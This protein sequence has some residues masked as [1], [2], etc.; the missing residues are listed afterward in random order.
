WRDL[1][2]VSLTGLTAGQFHTLS[3]SI[4]GDVQAALESSGTDLSFRIILNGPSGSQFIVDNLIVSDGGGS[5]PGDP[6]AT[7]QAF[8]L[9]VPR[10]SRVQDVIISGTG[11]VTIDDRSTISEQQA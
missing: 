1:G 11:K 4:P 3:F 9:S 8:S 5:S 2:G 10:G 6:G 7:G